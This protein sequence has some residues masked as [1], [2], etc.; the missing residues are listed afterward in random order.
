[1]SRS[2][3]SR[4]GFLAGTA[5]A[6][7]ALALTPTSHAATHALPQVDKPGRTPNTPFAV[8]IEMWFGGPA[9]K[10]IQE[11]AAL[12]YPSVEFWPYEGKNID[13]MATLLREHSMTAAQFTAWGFGRELNHPDAAPDNFLKAI[14]ESCAVAA[15]LPGC[16]MFTVVLGDNIDG[17]SKETM[18]KAAIEKLKRAVPILE[19]HRKM[20]IVEPMNPYNHPGHSLYGSKDGIA[21]CE[22]VGSE[23]VKLNWDLFHMQRYE[24]NLIDNMR[25]GRDF[26][27]Y[28][29][30]ADSP[31]R[32][33]P[34][35]GEVNYTNLF[36]VIRELDYKYPVGLECTPKDRNVQR[37][38]QRVYAAD[39]W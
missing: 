27:G 6:A 25:R 37:A 32:N 18:H 9:E 11:A 16:E 28:L 33:E 7:G 2:T 20:I 24:G 5:S 30:L 15:K 14:E 12:G 4:R 22:A 13:A 23:W 29:Q 17:L 21:I 26:I 1:M 38:A 39:T 10:R 8:N 19:K 35:T 3:L 36:R 34:G 31:D